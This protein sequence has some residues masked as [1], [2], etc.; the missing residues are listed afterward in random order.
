MREV[1]NALWPEKSGFCR[2]WNLKMAEPLLDPRPSHALP[3]RLR[4]VVQLTISTGRTEPS[5]MLC[6]TPP[7]TYSRRR[8][9]P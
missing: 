8:L 4:A 5:S 6:V 9:W 7:I 3:P 2:N 1:S